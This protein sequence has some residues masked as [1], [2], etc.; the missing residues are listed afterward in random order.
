MA[1]KS[2][3]AIELE[4]ATII[5]EGQNHPAV[6]EANLTINKLRMENRELKSN[7]F[8][9]VKLTEIELL[10]NAR[11]YVDQERLEELANS[12]REKG[13]I[14]PVQLIEYF[15]AKNNGQIKFG[16]VYGQRRYLASQIAGKE[17]IPAKISLAI[18][19]TEEMQLIENIHQETMK[20]KDVRDAVMEMY[21]KY[22]S[23][24][25]VAQKL[26]KT[27]SWVSIMVSA[28][29]V[30]ENQ[31]ADGA[32]ELVAGVSNSTLQIINTLPDAEDQ[33]KALTELKEA[34][35]TRLAARE[36]VDEMKKGSSSL[37]PS[38]EKTKVLQ[39]SVTLN[40]SGNVQSH[41]IS[42][43]FASEKLI[44][45]INTFFVGLRNTDSLQ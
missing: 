8:R 11:K 16:L 42:S 20:D 7:A 24:K 36:I 33:R 27:Q 34:G 44:E 4:K 30:A 21:I 40:D 35:G 22:N 25:L 26:G 15:E 5:S 10:E 3:L 13:V 43:G 6:I 12:I 38:K 29:N 39:V 18:D 28:A 14:Q 9:E 32:P 17:S 31:T 45:Q 37:K 2:A 23:Q 1:K 41:T 19:D